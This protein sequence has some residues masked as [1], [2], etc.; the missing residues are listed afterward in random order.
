MRKLI[1]ALGLLLFVSVHSDTAVAES[2]SEGTVGESV[3]KP[4]RRWLQQDTVRHRMSEEREGQDLRLW[5]R[6]FLKAGKD[7]GDMQQ[8]AA[9]LRIFIVSSGGERHD[10]GQ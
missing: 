10:F 9:L 7:Q 5:L 4:D 3:R 2:V 1:I 6:L 8:N